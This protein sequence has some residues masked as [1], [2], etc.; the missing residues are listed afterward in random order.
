MLKILVLAIAAA[1]A[2][3]IGL[4]YLLR[5]LF[6]QFEKDIALVALNVSA[7]PLGVVFVLSSIKFALYRSNLNLAWVDSGLTAG[8]IIALAYWLWRLMIDVVFYDLKKWAENSEIMWDNVLLPLLEAV[9]PVVIALVS[10]ALILQLSFGVDLSGIW[11]T[12]GGAS[13]IIGF[14]TKDILANF[15]SGIVLLIDTPFQFGDVLKFETGELGILQRI[16]LRVTQIY[17]FETHTEAYIPNSVLQAQKI[18]NVS[19]PI[20]PIYYSVPIVFPAR[21]DYQQCFEVMEKIILAHPDTIGDIDTK[22]EYLGQYFN[23]TRGT[24][25]SPRQNKI[26]YNRLVAEQEVN[27]K[28]QEIEENL[29]ALVLSLEIFEKDGLDSEE[30]ETIKQ[31]YQ[32][33]LELA[34]LEFTGIAREKK[35]WLSSRRGIKK[36]QL[37]ETK[38]KDSLISLVRKWYRIRLKDKNIVDEDQYILPK[39]WEYQ[40]ELLKKRLTRLQGQILNPQ[41]IETRL[42]DYVNKL[43]AWLKSGF[44]QARSHCHDPNVRL[45][46]VFQ[47]S[48][49]LFLKFSLNYYV[50]D[51]RLEDGKRGERVTSE[52]HREI[53]NHLQHLMSDKI[54][55]Q[56]KD[57]ELDKHDRSN[58]L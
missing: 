26:A 43:V 45:G 14:A 28:L 50:D 17:Q 39:I 2:F 3:Y 44:K 27:D 47:G 18:V 32:L 55:P 36:I 25:Y 58:N 54:L 29:E 48:T 24:N 11:V 52:I 7:Y 4:Y 30:I 1:I 15:F 46:T 53:L 23:W 16:G 22:L 12:L 35:S 20:E 10:L 41:L 49:E 34:G 31:D 8:I 6:R 40:I 51:I 19:R 37:E 5:K 42:D 33:V 21:C 9:T 56:N 38:D 13:F 57:I